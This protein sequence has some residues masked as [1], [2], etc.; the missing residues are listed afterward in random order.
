[1]ETPGLAIVQGLVA[2]TGADAMALTVE[3]AGGSQSPT[4]TPIVFGKMQQGPFARA[5][6]NQG[7]G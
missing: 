2:A 4:T 1:M 3:P 7:R 5:S 6:L